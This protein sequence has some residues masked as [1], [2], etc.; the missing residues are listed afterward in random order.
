MIKSTLAACA[1]L[2]GLAAGNQ[3]EVRTDNLSPLMLCVYRLSIQD[4]RMNSMNARKKKKD[5][6]SHSLLESASNG[7]PKKKI[8]N[9]TIG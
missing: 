3:L 1:A 6:V 4:Y 9:L 7:L 2:C 5:E 8:K